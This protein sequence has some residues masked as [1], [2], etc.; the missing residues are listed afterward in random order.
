VSIIILSACVF[1]YAGV[2][3]TRRAHPQNKTNAQSNGLSAGAATNTLD[4]VKAASGAESKGAT[5][6]PFAGAAIQNAQLEGSL[7]WTFGGKSQRGWGLYIPLIAHLIGAEANAG[8]NPFAARLA[9]WQKASGSEPNGVLDSDT[10]SRMV[11]E[12]QSRRLGVRTSP[13]PEQ[14]ITIPITNCYDPTRAEELRKAERETFAAYRR[15]VAEAAADPSLGLQTENGDLA[16]E[17]KY[18]KII[19]AYRSREYQDQ[20][21]RQSPNSGRAG[22]AINSPHATGRALDIYVGAEPVNTKDENRAIQVRTPVYRWL[23]VNAA[24]FG[25]RPY[26]YEPWHWEYVGVNSNTTK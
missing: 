15:M 20:L 5:Y 22:L 16:P 19:S 11:S 14:L 18:F 1:A 10:W 26:F 25:F 21:R 23:V 8:G 9:A 6:T 12:F 24:R 4:S 2:K 13:A 3:S 17:E 7:S